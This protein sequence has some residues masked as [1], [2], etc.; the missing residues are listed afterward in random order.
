MK[1][2]NKVFLAVFYTGSRFTEEEK[3]ENSLEITPILKLNIQHKS[4]P[5]SL[6][7]THIAENPEPLSCWLCSST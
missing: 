2:L 3:A 6:D 7:P 5:S 4:C 1:E